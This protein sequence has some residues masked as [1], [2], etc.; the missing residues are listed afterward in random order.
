MFSFSKII[1]PTIFAAALFSLF[2]SCNREQPSHFT[3]NAAAET[4]AQEAPGQAP[5]PQPEGSGASGGADIFTSLA[6]RPGAI[7]SLKRF[8]RTA[9]IRFRVK[10]V[11]EAT[12][13]I[14]D[15]AAQF[16]GFVIKSDLNTQITSREVESLSR[17]SAL[18]TT[19]FNIHNFVIIR[20]PYQNLDT[21]LRSIGR[22]SDFLDHRRIKA[23]DVGLQILEQQLEQL[24]QDIYRQ[25]LEAAP[26]TSAAAERNLGDK[27]ERNLRSRVATDQARIETMKTEDAIRYSTVQVNIYQFPQKRTAMIANVNHIPFERPFL[28]RAGDAL[29][30]GGQILANIFLGLLHLWGVLL[31]AVA[32]FFTWKR[33]A[34]KE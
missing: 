6:A 32:V 19:V 22:L 25:E 31:V 11:P 17:D 21:T 3:D 12:L 2:I 20:V 9:D 4:A 8:I 29:R 13:H 10:N 28:A 5:A 14:E 15:I 34:R 1:L 24:R 16:G 7:D 30:N 23:E 33:F 26:A 18:E 27:T